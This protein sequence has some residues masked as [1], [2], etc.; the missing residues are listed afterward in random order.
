MMWI[1]NNIYI[2]KT[3]SIHCSS[4]TIILLSLDITLF[5]PAWT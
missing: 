2:S 4:D 3:I 5:S 1:D